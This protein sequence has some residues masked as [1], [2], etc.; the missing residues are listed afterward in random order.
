LALDYQAAISLELRCKQKMVSS[1]ARIVSCGGVRRNNPGWEYGAYEFCPAPDGRH[2]RPGPAAAI[3]SRL[4]DGTIKT[5][6]L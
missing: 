2:A 1:E 5:T 6:I 4:F 3:P